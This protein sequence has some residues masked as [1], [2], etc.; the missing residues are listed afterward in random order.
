[1]GLADS[2]VSEQ[3][4]APPVDNVKGL[5]NARK[6]RLENVTRAYLLPIRRVPAPN[7]DVG[8]IRYAQ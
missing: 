7:A 8:V 1:M 4:Q 2:T 5:M 6:S 3:E